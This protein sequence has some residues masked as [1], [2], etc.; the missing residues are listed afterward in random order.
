MELNWTTYNPQTP[1]ERVLI[2]GPSLG[3]NVTHQWTRVAAQLID[4][5]RV[6]FVDLPGTGLAP[7]WDDDVEPTLDSVAAGIAKVA[8]Q[9][10]AEVGDDVPLWFAGLSISGATALH[11]ARDYADKFD[12]VFVVASSALVG[13][14]ERW[15]ERALHVEEKGTQ[16][17][18]EETTKRWFTP[19]FQAANAG[20]VDVIMEGLSVADDHSY[21]QLCR[22]LAVHDM[23]DDL[24][25]IRIP[26]IVIAGGRDSSNPIENQ[27]FVAENVLRGGL[28]VVD[29][30]AH[31]VPVSH[32]AEVAAIIQPYLHRGKVSR[33]VSSRLTEVSQQPP[34]SVSIGPA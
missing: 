12:G 32:P 29:D 25:L 4:E 5:A 28:H 24:P 1:A 15:L 18:V 27:E 17:L 20:I 7:V 16:S 14:P 2:V 22:A 33:V 34:E 19:T 8:D 6:V 10:R 23:R 21:A 30:A 9:V 26:V 11:V 31:Q 13:E 3:G